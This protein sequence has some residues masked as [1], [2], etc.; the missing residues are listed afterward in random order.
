MYQ[1]RKILKWEENNPNPLTQKQWNNLFIKLYKKTKQKYLFDV[2]YRFLSLRTTYSNQTKWNK[3]IRIPSAWDVANRKKPMNIGCSP[4][5]PR[6]ILLFTLYY[7]KHIDYTF[8]NTAIDCL[9]KPLLLEN[10][11][12]LVAPELHEM[13]SIHKR[14]IRKNATYRTLP[15]WHKQLLTFQDKIKGWKHSFTKDFEALQ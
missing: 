15:S 8:Q 12:F 4:A 6:R 10:D 7:V 13:C 2:R 5:R 3:T 1:N 14:N 9:L 11:K